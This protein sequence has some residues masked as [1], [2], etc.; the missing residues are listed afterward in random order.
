MNPLVE[1]PS[2]VRYPLAFLLPLVATLLLTPVAAKMAHRFGILD[3]PEGH[4]AHPEPTPY[5]GGVAVIAGMLVVGALA[6]GA[7]GQLLTIVTCAVG[8]MLL[9]LLDDR[10]GL[11]PIVRVAY[12]AAA[13]G[14]LYLAGVR[15]SFGGPAWVD[16]VATMLWVVAVTNAV[17]LLDNMDGL[18]SGVAAV[19]AFGVFAI[20]AKEGAFL[21]ASMALAVAGASIGFLRHNFPPARI[22]LGDAGSLLLGFMLA[23]MAL[24]LD[25]WVP[26]SAVRGVVGVLVVGVPLFDMGLVVI[27][28]LRGRR[29]VYLGARDHSSHRLVALG[30]SARTVAIVVIATQ[31]VCSAA[32]FV[33][34]RRSEIFVLASAGVLAIAGLLLLALLLR[35]EVLERVEGRGLT[36]GGGPPTPGGPS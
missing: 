28:R 18:A 31:L 24:K 35:V 11:S 15:A 5:L 7:S 12:E 29:P 1:L 19:S 13:G 17:N 27:A 23:T 36:G 33:L 6:A 34:Y 30:L 8:M 16:V 4:K 20:A 26:S 3:H 2:A 25:L 32:A 10:A 22:F 14:A 21:D 9:G